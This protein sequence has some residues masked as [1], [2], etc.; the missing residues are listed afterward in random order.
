MDKEFNKFGAWEDAWHQAFKD[1][2]HA[3]PNKVWQGL[4][5]SLLEQQLQRY[6]RKLFLYQWLAAASVV[7]LGLW[8]GW[9]VFFAQ[10]TSETYLAAEKNTTPT[11]IA[12]QTPI[13]E[14]DLQNSG[15]AAF[16][17]SID[18]G[19]AQEHKPSSPASTS[20]GIAA[21]SSG[22]DIIQG[23][24]DVPGVEANVVLAPA[25]QTTGNSTT[26]AAADRTTKQPIAAVVESSPLPQV[27]PQTL[28]VERTPEAEN[29]WLLALNYPDIKG[30][31]AAL[32][33]ERE[34]LTR[35]FV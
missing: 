12:Q 15:T 23:N 3:P 19:D 20:Q 2:E 29:T 5:N 21:S 26:L 17:Q 33:L 13:A 7:L 4:E 25:Q 9:W 22:V 28:A 30:L 31:K 10:P 8:T 16:S 35:T 14:E 24:A 32:A 27:T 1:A 11:A 18:K 6:K 34:T